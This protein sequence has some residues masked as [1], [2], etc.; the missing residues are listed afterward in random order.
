[1]ICIQQTRKKKNGWDI[2]AHPSEWNIHICL[3]QRT[4]VGCLSIPGYPHIVWHNV[5][6]FPWSFCYQ[7]Q[8]IWGF[9][10]ARGA[11]EKYTWRKHNIKLIYDRMK[12]IWVR[13]RNKLTFVRFGSVIFCNSNVYERHIKKNEYIFFCSVRFARYIGVYFFPLSFS[14]MN[15]PPHSLPFNRRQRP[16]KKADVIINL[17]VCMYNI[18]TVNSDNRNGSHGNSNG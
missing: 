18:W 9:I 7:I 15:F 16:A 17:C 6:L 5:W 14:L 12:R 3:L 11:S 4:C 13:Q 8:N 2:D 1:M 10:S